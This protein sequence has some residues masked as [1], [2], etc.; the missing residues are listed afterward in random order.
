MRTVTRLLLLWM[1]VVFPVAGWGGGGG[2]GGG[3]TVVLPGDDAASGDLGT[4]VDKDAYVTPDGADK[5][6]LGTPDNGN[7]EEDIPCTCLDKVCGWD[8]CGNSCGTCPDGYTCLP[9]GQCQP[10]APT[11]PT[12][13]FQPVEQTVD[14]QEQASGG[15]LLHYQALSSQSLP[16]DAVVIDINAIQ[17]NNGP[18]GPGT[19]DLKYKNLQSCGLCMYLL[20]G[21]NGQ[22]YSKILVPTQ[23]T[24][25][26]TSYNPAGGMFTGTFQ[27]VVLKEATVNQ[28][29]L[30]VSVVQG[31]TTWCLDG[32][33]AN[34][35]IMVTQDYCVEKGT[36]IMLGDNIK[37][38]KL[39]NCKGETVG[40]HS[41]CGAA[42][43]VWVVATA[44][45]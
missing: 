3:D 6:D 28:N 44:G 43:A 10:P 33:Q 23:G 15:F 31:G 30:D 22:G 39:Q 21:W 9:S 45:W 24:L 36:G 41:L 2:G 16:L 17:P 11:C 8:N 13:G 1:L 42:K 38:F 19:Y 32:Y 29:T 12:N 4:P 25:N 20:Q 27:G 40:L 34:A 35:E 5:Q 37:N 26:I 14:V 7:P 18:T